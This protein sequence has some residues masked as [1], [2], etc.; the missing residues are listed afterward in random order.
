MAA[1]ALSEMLANFVASLCRL[2]KRICSLCCRTNQVAPIKVNE[3]NEPE[4]LGRLPAVLVLFA[5]RCG[6]NG[7]RNESL[8]SF[9]FFSYL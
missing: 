4:V 2:A 7:T 8:G 9:L 1:A 5:L 3:S 6:R